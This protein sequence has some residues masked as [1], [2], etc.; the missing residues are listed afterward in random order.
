MQRFRTVLDPLPMCHLVSR[1]T[2][3][4]WFAIWSFDP[5][6]TFGS[7]SGLSTHQGLL[8]VP[9]G[10]STHQGL[11]VRHLVFRPTKDFWFA[12]WSF[13]PPRTF[14]CAIGL[15]THQGLLVVPS[16]LSTR[17]RIFQLPVFSSRGPQRV[18][19][20]CKSSHPTIFE[21]GKKIQSAPL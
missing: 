21:A 3:D 19:A 10:F 15:S 6:R 17:R 12:I 14:G 20:Q 2:K 18:L 7:P 8:V 5:P 4:F 9:S 13:D 16:D 11:L 1:P